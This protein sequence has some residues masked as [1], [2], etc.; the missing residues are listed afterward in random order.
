MPENP[1]AQASEEV[2][3]PFKPN[4]KMERCIQDVKKNLRRTRKTLDG[5]SIKSASI[6]ICRSRLKQ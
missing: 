2:A 1:L 5:Q 6:A 4:A 3:A